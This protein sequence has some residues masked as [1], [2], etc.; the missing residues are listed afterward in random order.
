MN[1][2]NKQWLAIVMVVL[3]V[4]TASTSQMT[5]IFGAELAKHLTSG[6][7]LLNSILAGVAAIVSSQA[8]LIGD[9]QG[10]RGVE[11]IT[12]NAMANT[13]LASMAVDPVNQK[14]EASPGAAAAVSA[15][16]RN[17]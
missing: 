2:T 11:K 16:A 7:A 9:V 6:A 5:E 14:V 12:V 13:T 8:S 15:T 1:I 10:M 17:A 3:G 4:M